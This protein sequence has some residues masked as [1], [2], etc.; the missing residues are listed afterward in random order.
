MK[1]EP[2]VSD[3]GCGLACLA[4]LL[5]T[6]YAS[7]SDDFPNF[8]PGYGVDEDVMFHFLSDRGYASRK[9][10]PY[11]KH[12][13]AV[14]KPWPPRPFAERH[15]VLLWQTREDWR[16]DNLANAFDH[17]HYVVMTATG[18]V[19]DPADKEPVKRRLRDY[20]RVIWVAGLWKVG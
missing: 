15:L 13:G 2:Q 3:T 8:I 17:S 20:Y 9:I 16:R 5:D 4:M 19:L 1:W 14:R 12:N 6:R 10:E 7:V 11:A 18:H